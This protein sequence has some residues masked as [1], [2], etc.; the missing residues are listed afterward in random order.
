MNLHKDNAN[1]NADPQAPKGLVEDLRLLY[2]T[3][4]SVP[5]E[6]DAR[7]LETARSRF[8][9][10]RV[11]VRVL[12]WGALTAAAGVLLVSIISIPKWHAPHNAPASQVAK[13]REDL[14]ADGRVDILDAFLLARLINESRAVPHNWDL[15]GDGKIDK[16]DVDLVAAAAVNLKRRAL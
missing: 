11:A 9:R 14:N 1:G 7:V 3:G 12:R 15:N 2:G 8:A 5:P 10:R 6:V 16:R 13:A 4:A